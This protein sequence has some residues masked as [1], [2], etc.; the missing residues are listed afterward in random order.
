[1]AFLL[2][3]IWECDESGSEWLVDTTGDLSEARVIAKACLTGDICET[4]IYLDNDNDDV[5][6]IERHKTS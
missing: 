2:Y 1:M 4:I 3:E 6:E 5:I